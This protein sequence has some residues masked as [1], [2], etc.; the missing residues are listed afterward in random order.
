[1]KYYECWEN[2]GSWLMYEVT[3]YGQ[4]WKLVKTFRTRKGA[5]NWAKKNWYRVEWR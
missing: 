5:E 1:M 3:N 2:N 4:S